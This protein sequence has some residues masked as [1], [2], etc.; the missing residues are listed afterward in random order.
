LGEPDAHGHVCK[1]GSLREDTEEDSSAGAVPWTI[2]RVL[3]PPLTVQAAKSN[4]R[5]VS[6]ESGRTIR[7]S[8]L[9]R[10]QTDGLCFRRVAHRPGALQRG[11]I[12][13]DASGSMQLSVQTLDALCKAL[14]AATIAIYSGR[15][16]GES[17][18]VVIGRSG[19]RVAEVSKSWLLGG[20]VCDGPALLWLSRQPGPRLWLCDGGV[21]VV[22]DVTTA[23]AI[24]ECSAIIQAA[25]IIQL[26]GR[27]IKPTRTLTRKNTTIGSYADLLPAL[28]AV[29]RKMI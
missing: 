12:L 21:T 16:M 10:V 27:P 4:A 7:W 14:P 8:S 22:G 19:R 26:C 5:V 29:E 1:G 28:R 2:P 11:T 25:G 24:A 6:A 9:Y 15:P 17:L 18:I 20:N 23:R 13:I 3:E